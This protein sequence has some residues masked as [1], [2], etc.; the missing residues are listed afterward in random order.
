MNKLIKV[1][2]LAGGLLILGGCSTTNTSPQPNYQ[3]TY[4]GLTTQQYLDAYHGRIDQP[5]DGPYG[6]E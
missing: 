4:N 2:L 5:T 1:L 6:V 3:G